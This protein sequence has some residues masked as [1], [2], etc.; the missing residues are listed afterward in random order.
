M[1]L[2]MVPDMPDLFGDVQAWAPLS[3]QDHF[4]KSGFSDKV[5]AVEAYDHAPRRFREPF[6]RTLD[7]I[8]VLVAAA[9]VQA[10]GDLMRGLDGEVLRLNLAPYQTLVRRLIETASGIIHGS[11]SCMDQGEIDS[12]LSSGMTSDASAAKGSSQADIDALFG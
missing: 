9:I 5:L 11:E 12:L 4:R 2:D 6:D 10:E 3:Y 8:N 7:Q 1:L